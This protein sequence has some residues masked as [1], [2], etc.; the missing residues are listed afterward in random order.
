M[1]R[2]GITGGIGSGKSTVAQCLQRFC[3]SVIL[4]ADAISR[5][6]TAP[7][8]LAI[9]A[10][11]RACGTALI[12]Q[13]GGI[14]RS[15]VRQRAFSDPTFRQTLETIIHPIVQA[16]M[17]RIEME[18]MARSVPVLIYDIPLLVESGK[19]RAHLHQV[20]VVD[21]SEDT[22]VQR[23]QSRNQMQ[24]KEIRAIIRAQATRTQRLACADLVVCNDGISLQE[25]EKQCQQVSTILHG[26]N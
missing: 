3:Q 25:L 16:E 14:N 17:A 24:A 19:W 8:G 9:P 12:A 7:G 1:I 26:K 10:L 6:S 15:A 18:C 23:V 21:C 4:D 5:Q 11:I 20:L 13:D 2:L 22:Q